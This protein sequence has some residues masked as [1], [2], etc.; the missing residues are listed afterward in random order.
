M[1]IYHDESIFNTNEGQTWMWREE[2]RPA[3]LPKTKGSGI[4][5]SGFV[6]EHRLRIQMSKEVKPRN[7]PKCTSTFAVWSG[8]GGLLDQ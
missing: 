1:V 4:M 5:V 2:N 6:E 3:I 7:C 8:K